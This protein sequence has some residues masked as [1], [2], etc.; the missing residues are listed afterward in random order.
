MENNTNKSAKT[1]LQC[2]LDEKQKD[3]NKTATEQLKKIYREGLDAVTGSGI[4]DKAL[5][6]GNKAP[7]FTLT[8]A[9]N[10]SVNLYDQ[11]RKG[12]VVLTW[13]RGG[14][15]PYCNITLRYLQNKLPDFQNEGAS[16]IALTPEL[17]DQSLNT[18]EKNQLQFEVLS[19][20]G[21]NVGK[22]YGIIFQLTREVAA[23]YQQAFDLHSHNGDESDELPLAATYVIGQDAII[24]YAY[25][26][27]D[28][29]YRAD[30]EIIIQHLKQI[31][32]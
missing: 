28:Y 27:V 3:F 26:N 7:D 17:P 21:N 12:P 24:Q 11:L 4:L 14:W 13:Y 18:A 20:V 16:L 2:L 1:T 22:E 25:L 29:K 10:Q 31:G 6:A 5:N 30:P 32:K 23:N 9:S 8:N 19:D 15:C